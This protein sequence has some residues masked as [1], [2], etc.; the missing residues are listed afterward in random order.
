MPS[1][2]DR[3]HSESKKVD[4]RD[5]G[6][7]DRDRVLYTYALRRLAGVTQVVGPLE[8]QLFH[9]RLTHTIEVAQIARRI[10]EKLVTEHPTVAKKLGGIDA[11]VVEAAALAHDLGHPPFGHVA[12]HELDTLARRSGDPDGFEGNAQSFRIVTRLAAHDYTY[13]GINLSRA[14]LN[15]ILKYPWHRARKRTTGK[16]WRKFGAYRTEARGLTFARE[17]G[18][19]GAHQS[20]EASIMDYADAVAYSVHDLDDFF[21]AGLISV[22]HL[23][24]SQEEF[25]AFLLRWI[26]SGKV[27][28][29]E[30]TKDRRAGLKSLL[31]DSFYFARPYSGTFSERAE[32]RKRTSSLIRDYV[33]AASLAG[34]SSK[35][36]G[37]TF[38]AVKLLEMRFFQRLVWEFVISNPKL[39]TQQHGQ[40]RVIRTLYDVYLGAVRARTRDLIPPLFHEEL[41]S[42]NKAAKK[43]AKPTV[44]EI[45]LAVDIVASFTDNQAVLM[46]R[47]LTGVSTGSVADLLEG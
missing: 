37:V 3:L 41:A 9:N 23:Q 28:A 19:W 12:E 30:L 29:A 22:E 46:Y 35:T 6:P 4:Q 31:E 44:P 5:F 27:D 17:G 24:N 33:F 43:T 18:K 47:R 11:D 2:H 7:R 40:R 45:R 21:R 20:P 42:L 10:A 25:D 14:T 15:A 26:R 16:R 1:R 8:G 36:P 32:L 39:A 38:D 13:R 34:P